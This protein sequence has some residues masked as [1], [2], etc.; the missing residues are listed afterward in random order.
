MKRPKKPLVYARKNPSGDVVYR[1]AYV[2]PAT[3]KRIQNVFGSRKKDAEMEANRIY[4][5]LLARYW[6][7]DLRKLQTGTLEQVIKAY[8]ASR[9]NRVRPSTVKRYQIYFDNFLNFM[10]K[11]YR[12]VKMI[13]DV[14]GR[15]VEEFLQ[16]LHKAGQAPGTINAEIRMVKTIF[17]YAVREKYLRESPVA[18]IEKFKDEKPAEE[19]LWWTDEEIELIFAEVQPH[20]RP[21]YQFIYHTGIREG[22]AINLTWNAVSL[23]GNL[24]VIKIQ[25][26]KDWVPKTCQRR[27]VPLNSAALSI[28]KSIPKHKEHNYVFTTLEGHK[29]KEK[30]IYDNLVNPVNRL[31]KQGKV[32]YGTPHTLRHTFASHLV[33]RGI[34]LEKISKL[35]GHTSTEMTMKYAHL[36]PDTLAEA[37]NIL[38][39]PKV[40][41]DA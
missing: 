6:G 30:T 8:V 19:L 13:A 11:N 39:K 20:W 9:L 28:I 24:P 5:E 32:K 34:G 26:S 25:A 41:E 18:Q 15:Y 4:N 3:G 2:D 1:I 7:E 10:K 17:D 21:I 35:L 33:K 31:V 22:E 16:S 40:K 23:D 38:V 27:E 29:I 36:A 12:S 37:V 14:K